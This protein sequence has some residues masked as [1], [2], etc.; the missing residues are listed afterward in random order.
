V[1]SRIWWIFLSGTPR[2]PDPPSDEPSDALHN[3]ASRRVLNYG[4]SYISKADRPYTDRAGPHLEGAHHLRSGH[5]V[6]VQVA[7]NGVGGLALRA[8]P[9]K[10]ATTSSGVDLGLPSVTPFSFLTCSASR[11][12]IL[13]KSRSNSAKTTAMCAIALPSAY[14]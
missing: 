7:G 9:Q 14:G 1:L 10:R 3:L 8:L 12:R 6:L 2:K 11:V 13:M 4:G 5:S